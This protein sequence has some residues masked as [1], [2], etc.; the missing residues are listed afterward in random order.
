[1]LLSD[2]REVILKIL[3]E[4]M[5]Q[6]RWFHSS[7]VLITSEGIGPFYDALCLRM[8]HFICQVD[9]AQTITHPCCS[10]GHTLLWLCPQRR[11]MTR[12]YLQGSRQHQFCCVACSVRLGSSCWWTLFRHYDGP[13]L[14]LYA[15]HLLLEG[16][17]SVVVV[18]GWVRVAYTETCVLIPW[19]KVRPILSRWY[20]HLVGL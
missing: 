17:G 15:R 20:H 14:R 11:V 2:L 8:Q 13:V 12:R 3:F 19:D 5:H 10:H 1:M 4:W 6:H 7:T 16:S 9:S 18:G